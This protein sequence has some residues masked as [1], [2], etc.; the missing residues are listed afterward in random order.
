[1]AAQRL[2][3]ILTNVTGTSKQLL[4]VNEAETGFEF[5]SPASLPTYTITNDITDRAIDANNIT[6]DEV[7]DVLSTLI[8]DMATIYSGGPAKFQ[9]STSEQ[10]WPFELDDSGRTLYCKKMNIGALPNNGIKNT[11]H[12]ISSLTDIRKLF[13]FWSYSQTNAGNTLQILNP[14]GYPGYQTSVEVNQTNVI[15]ITQGANS[16]YD[17]IIYLMYAK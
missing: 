8:K 6:L 11:A 12:N 15:F 1:M 3:S 13:K 5:V 16:G 2:G 9:W 4:R 14:D 7:G 10:E 17:G